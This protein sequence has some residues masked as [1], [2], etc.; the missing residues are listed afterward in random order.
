MTQNKI[1]RIDP[2]PE[3]FAVTWMLGSLCNYD[4]MYCAPE[5][6]DTTSRPHD[7]ETMK[8]AWRNIHEKSQV[9]G[10]PFKISIT[11]GEP[12]ANKNFLPLIQ[13][14]RENY[15]DIGWIGVTTNGSASLRYYKNLTE[16]VEAITFSTHSE[17]IHESEFFKKVLVLDRMMV[18]PVKSFHVSI[19]NEFWNQ[20]RIK[21]YDQWLTEHDISHTID[22]IDYS[23]RIREDFVTKGTLD[24]ER[25]QKSS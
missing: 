17:F 1:I 12:T 11:G 13:W 16:F 20:D 2:V 23:Q 7:L 8:Q 14:L 3:H 15:A 24:F 21:M 25:I 22:E 18:R 4:C 19:M 10:L 9:R 5:W 6:H